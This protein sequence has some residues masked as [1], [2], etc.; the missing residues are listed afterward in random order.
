MFVL[1][2]S[3]SIGRANNRIALQ[4]LSSVIDFFKI[5][6]NATQVGL[7]TYSTHAY[8]RFDLDDYSSKETIQDKIARIDYPGGWTATAL[9]LFQAGVILNPQ[10]RRG[11]RPLTE[12][13]PR[14]TVL[15]TDGRSNRLPIDEV[16]ISLHAS[17]VQVYAVG[18]GN[19]YLPELKFIAS[20][21]DRL[22]VY[23]L[24]SFNDAQGFVDFLSFTTCDSE[25]FLNS[26]WQVYFKL[27]YCDS[28]LFLK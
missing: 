15:V 18:I 8:V 22:H 19:I 4:F 26:I 12:G 17:G 24:D 28:D 7:I 1:D 21:P 9:G 2:Q 27:T 25:L 10:Q 20:D 3:G 6:P 5:S 13:I 23:L 11:A 14:V 16:T